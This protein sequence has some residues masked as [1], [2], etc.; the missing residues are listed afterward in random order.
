MTEKRFHCDYKIVN[1]KEFEE[2]EEF[3][4]DYYKD[5]LNFNAMME[6]VNNRI[7]TK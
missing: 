2:P 6:D 4:D 1:E 3:N 7:E 5:N